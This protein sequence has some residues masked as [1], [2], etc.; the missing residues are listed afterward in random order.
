MAPAPTCKRKSQ[1][2]SGPSGLQDPQRHIC[3]RSFDTQIA[4]YA[5]ELPVDAAVVMCGAELLRAGVRARCGVLGLTSPVLPTAHQNRAMCGEP[6]LSSAIDAASQR[7]V[8]DSRRAMA[9]DH[10]CHAR[11]RLLVRCVVGRRWQALASEIAE[12]DTRIKSILDESPT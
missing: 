8:R 5:L 10:H 6:V 7:S 9:A 11:R 2:I 4:G 3:A 12:L 1:Q